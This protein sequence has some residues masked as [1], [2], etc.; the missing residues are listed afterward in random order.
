MV[1]NKIGVD[2][3]IVITKYN[4]IANC[5]AYSIISCVRE[6][7]YKNFVIV[8]YISMLFYDFHCFIMDF[9][10]LV[11]NDNFGIGW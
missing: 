10:T 9:L 1:F 4:Y 8:Y 3:Y 6:S 11:C 2:Y 7:P 5:F